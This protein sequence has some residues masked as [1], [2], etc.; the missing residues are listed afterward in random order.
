MK[1]MEKKLATKDELLRMTGI[2]G[3]MLPFLATDEQNKKALKENLA[4][5]QT[6]LREKI[7]DDN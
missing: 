5:F 2:L 4:Q 6:E 3:R 7:A 1:K